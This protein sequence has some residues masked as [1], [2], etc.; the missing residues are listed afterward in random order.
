VILVLSQFSPSV[1]IFNYFEF[2]KE[3]F[4]ERYLSRSPRR[5]EAVCTQAPNVWIKKNHV[6]D[7]R[8]FQ[9]DTGLNVDIDLAITP[10]RKST[11]GG[12]MCIGENTSKVNIERECDGVDYI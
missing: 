3:S 11:H 8:I 1:H 5:A 12:S 10:E 2:T 9:N 4:G 7:T 6:R